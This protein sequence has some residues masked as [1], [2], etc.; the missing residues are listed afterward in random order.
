MDQSEFDLSFLEFE[1]DLFGIKP[2]GI[3]VWE[4]MRFHV[5]R[6]ILTKKGL[7]D[8]AHPSVERN[9]SAYLRGGYLLL[10]NVVRQNPYLFSESDFLFYGHPRRKLQS[11][12][13]WWDVYCDPI[14]K[15]CEYDYLQI[16]SNYDLKHYTPPRTENLSYLDI[17]DYTDFLKRQ[18]GLVDVTLD[19]ESRNAFDTASQEISSRFGVEIDLA[20]RARHH[21]RQRAS[22]RPLY[23]KLLAN[24]DPNLVVVVCSYGKETFIEVS[25]NQNI[26]VVELQHGVIYDGHKGY[27]FPDDRTKDTFPD[28][29]LTWGEF[30]G[31]DIEFP[32]PDD[33]VI[34]VGYPYLEQRRDH[35]ADTESS[36]QILFISQGTIGKEL[37]KFALEVGKHPNIDHDIV[38]KLHPGEYDRWQEEY[39]WLLDADFKVIDSSE[40]PLYE[41]FAKSSS[42]IGVGS[43]AVYEGLAYDLET[44][45]YDCPGSEILEPLLDDGSATLVSSADELAETFG[46][47][48]STFDKERY[49]VTN[50]TQNICEELDGLAD[51]GSSCQSE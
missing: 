3:T 33:Q 44:Y 10:R 22:R 46:I 24:V 38:Y 16:E 27:S 43:T 37:S 50:A 39:P 8:K 18:F 19:R 25:K 49:F 41:L 17:I 12:G 11:D 14:H 4:W 45:V 7:V 5:Y 35:Y 26:P 21:L 9:L 30:W 15:E 34:P 29:L 51:A 47:G 23:K 40:P 48:Q 13:Y 32:I 2:H 36:E 42:Q 31:R 1:L 6:E 20:E 28:Y